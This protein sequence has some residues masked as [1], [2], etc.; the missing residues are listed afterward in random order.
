MK[1]LL[2][3]LAVIAGV[4]TG[5]NNA[6]TAKTDDSTSHNEGT[7]D[8][9]K[10]DIQTPEKVE[11]GKDVDL[12][13]HLTQGGKNVDDADEVKFEVWESGNRD[14]GQMLEGKL[15]KDGIYKATTKFNHD[16]VYYMYAHTTAHGLHAMPKKKIVVGNPDMKKVKEDQDD[17]SM[18]GMDMNN[19]SADDH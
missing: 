9:V 17:G 16:G 12:V 15:D 10:V 18:E 2:I 4:L 1:K 3:S 11:V 6:N 14:K 19:S 7:L 5:C 8:E 13:A